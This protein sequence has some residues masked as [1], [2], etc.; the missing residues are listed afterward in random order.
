[1]HQGGLNHLDYNATHIL[2]NASG[3]AL[4]PQ[5]AV[6]DLQ[7][8]AT[9]IFSSWR[10]PI[11]TLAEL[12]YTLPSEL[13]DEDERLFMLATYLGKEKLTLHDRLLWRIISAKTK[14][15][16]RHTLK[17]RARR[18]R[19]RERESSKNEGPWHLLIHDQDLGTVEPVSLEKLLRKVPGRREVWAGSWRSRQVIVKMFQSRRKE[20]HVTR[21]WQ[22]LRTLHERGIPAPLALFRGKD[23]RGHQVL[24]VNQ[25][26]RSVSVTDLIRRDRSGLKTSAVFPL[27]IQTL[28]QQHRKGVDQKD[29]H[30]GNFL[31]QGEQIFSLDPAEMRFS[32]RPLGKT[33]SLTRLAE[34]GASLP[35]FE[36]NKFKYLA[37]EYARARQWQLSAQ[38]LTHLEAKRQ[39]II[40]R[41]L[42]QHL[43]KY[44]RSNTRHQEVIGRHYRLLIDR[45]TGWECRAPEELAAVLREAALGQC[46]RQTERPIIFTWGTQQL[47]A[48]RFIEKS[49]IKRLWQG[50]FPG[51]K[52]ALRFWQ[53]LYR[54]Q[55][56]M[57]SNLTPVGLLQPISPWS[58]LSSFVITKVDP[59]VT[60]KTL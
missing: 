12:N 21:E 17:R 50:L 39:K 37:L 40:A 32:Q 36:S 20:C 51:G 41:Q 2:L 24:V 46:A 47:T 52:Q 4:D 14:K 49:L 9:S 28:A 44:S 26:D 22:G 23:S 42:K 15:I 19:E 53:E 5:V 1:M 13:F 55:S 16:E 3:Q 6:F 10:W 48:S 25:I 7:R 31:L 27:L 35:E 60:G 11:K 45:R 29:L 33:R 30:P 58:R 18:R 38:A 57:D 59:I 34:L 56:T 54:Q 43:K 8:I